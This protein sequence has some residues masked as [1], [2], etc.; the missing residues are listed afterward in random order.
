MPVSKSCRLPRV[1]PNFGDLLHGRGPSAC[2]EAVRLYQG[3]HV[4]LICRHR[5]QPFPFLETSQHINAFDG[6]GPIADPLPFLDPHSVAPRVSGIM[7]KA[8]PDGLAMPHGNDAAMLLHDR[9]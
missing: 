7:G 4:P 6:Y 9:F 5:S 3:G 8:L 1:F 2:H